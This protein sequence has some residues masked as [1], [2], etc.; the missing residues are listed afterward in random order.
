[1]DKY[2][3]P[4]SDEYFETEKECK[5]KKEKE[6]VKSFEIETTKYKKTDIE[7]KTTEYEIKD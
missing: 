2:F 3:E 6:E 7:V 1:M 4:G 5:E